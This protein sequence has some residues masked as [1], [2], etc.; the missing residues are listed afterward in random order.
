MFNLVKFTVSIA[1]TCAAV[2]GMSC[3]V[4]FACMFLFADL[5]EQS[6]SIHESTLNAGMGWL[7]GHGLIGQASKCF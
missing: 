1:S 6:T 2:L 7:V 4:C 3:H 5:L